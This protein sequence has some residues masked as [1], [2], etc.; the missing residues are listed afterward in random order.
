MSRVL[1][2][3]ALLISTTAV[4][5]TRYTVLMGGNKAGIQT[6]SV[7]PDGVREMN[8]E[9]NDRGRGPKLTARIKVNDAGLIT[10]LQTNGND[11]LKVPVK[12]TFTLDR[13]VARWQNDAEKGEKKLTAPAYYLSLQTVPEETALLANALLKAKGHALPL[14]PEGQAAIQRA[15]ETTVQSDQGT[16]R[17]TSYEISGL[18]FSPEIVWLEQDGSFFASVSSW[19]VTIREGWESSIPKLLELQNARANLRAKE[20][21]SALTRHPAAFAIVNANLFDSQTG[22]STPRTTVLVQGNRIKAVGADGKVS[23]PANA[24]RIDAR[25]RAL[26]PGLADMHVHLGEGEGIQHLAAGVTLVRDLA[27]DTD[28]LLA[29]KGRIEKGDEIGPRIFMSGI[30]D[31]P[32]PFA[33]PTKVLV[34]TEQEINEAVDNYAKL[35]YQGVKIYSSIQ[36]ELVPVIIKRAHE[37]GL[38]VGGHVPAFMTAR[39]FIEAGADEMQHI[40]F[41]FLNFFFDDVKDTRTP[42]RFTTIAQRAAKLD[43]NSSEVRSFVQ[44]LRDKQVVVDPTVTILYSMF[45]DRPGVVGAA[46]AP[47]AGRLPPQIRRELQAGGLPIPAGSEQQYRDSA[48]AMLRMVKLLY[49]SGITLVA[50]TDNLPGFTLHRELEMYV[51]AGIPAPEVLRIAT[52]T[53]A[54]VLKRDADLGSITPGKLADM[55]LVEGDPA[56]RIGDIR[57]TELVI[58]DGKLYE[59]PKLYRTIGV[60]PR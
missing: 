55:I 46:Y 3:I 56:R 29:L 23:I 16:R 59:V 24:E 42:A 60:L 37:K 57:N 36:P 52:L 12:E 41:V 50:G 47:I 1:T 48:D 10:Q 31:G 11:Y 20:H 40:N 35:G 33:G 9:Y 26:L 38:R 22:K 54:K 18:G 28:A 44:L 15:D 49:D 14:L 51:Q 6:S 4:A 17:V 2:L 34:D 19:F 39:Q 8:F 32:G 13:G 25:G 45:T 53:A 58:K 27:G 7:T 5:D 30:L 21:V 43:F